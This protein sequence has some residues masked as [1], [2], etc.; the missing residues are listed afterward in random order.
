MRRKQPRWRSTLPPKLLKSVALTHDS[1]QCV[2]ELQHLRPDEA[3]LVPYRKRITIYHEARLAGWTTGEC[4]A[5]WH[6]K[7]NGY[8][9]QREKI[10]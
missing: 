7:L 1:A 10:S 8:I 2:T 3:L 4:R 9:V 6:D 5:E